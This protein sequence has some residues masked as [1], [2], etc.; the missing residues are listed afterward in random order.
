MH[1]EARARITFEADKLGGRPCIRGYRISVT[2]VLGMLA[3][4]VSQ[5]EILKD[6]DFL[7]AADLKACLEYAAEE[8]EHPVLIAAG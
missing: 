8:V 3:A 4:G 7:E 5:A 1:A 6:Y 2:D